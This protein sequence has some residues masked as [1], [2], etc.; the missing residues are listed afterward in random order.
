MTDSTYDLLVLLRLRLNLLLRWSLS[1]YTRSA[2]T[3]APIRLIVML[4]LL[5]WFLSLLI[6]SA[7]TILNS[8]LSGSQ[9]RT[10]VAPFLAW[11]T[12]VTALIIFLYAIV[13]L[14]GTLTY[15]S[16]LK[17]LL[18]TPISPR[19]ILAEKILAVSLGF[20]PLLLLTLP[21][22]LGIGHALHL[23]PIYDLMVL[24]MV[25]LVPIGPVSLAM[26]LLLAV[27][28]LVPPARVQT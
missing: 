17:L 1:R 2:K 16:D 8:V 7:T 14:A 13:T 6:R 28:R 25:I 26:L 20:S 5:L 4:L 9:G 27:L 11:G 21:A 24:A 10:I 3:A 19:V 15:R 23:G 18:L 22:V 12:S